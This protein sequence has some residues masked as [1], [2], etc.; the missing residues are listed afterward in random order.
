[1]PASKHVALATAVVMA[2]GLAPSAGLAAADPCPSLYV[3]YDNYKIDV[4]LWFDR[5]G[6]Q[7]DF[8]DEP[9]GDW[10]F[11]HTQ[12]SPW[13]QGEGYEEHHNE[14]HDNGYADSQHL[15]CGPLN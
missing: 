4:P 9:G 15:M 2:V 7:N 6:H 14:F 1:V 12:Y 5:H 13:E 3:T 8:L 10:E 11:V